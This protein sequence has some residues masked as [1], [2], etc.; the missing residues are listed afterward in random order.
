[1]AGRFNFTSERARVRIER[2]LSLLSEQHMTIRQLC[3]ILYATK[4]A[5]NHYI[6]HLRDGKNKRIYIVGYVDDGGSR[7]SAAYAV[8]SK[9]DAPYPV[10]SKAQY[11][12]E[13][14]SDPDRHA[15]HLATQERV[16]IRKRGREHLIR[17][18][19]QYEKPLA[20]LAR[21]H[22]EAF[23]GS[24]TRQTC[25]KLGATLSGTKQAIADLKRKGIIKA[26][27][28]TRAG[29]H[30]ELATRKTVR[31]APLVTKPQ[32]IFAALGV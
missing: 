12:Q 8:G 1:M 19:R 13:V 5:L 15:H 17:E 9:K 7:L 31:H 2:I 16:R 28:R 29:S 26:E 14:K 6:M 20:E 32:G 11:W 23:P 4:S 18:C 10:K 25:E 21:A 27:K 30:W 3:E 22:I 24:T